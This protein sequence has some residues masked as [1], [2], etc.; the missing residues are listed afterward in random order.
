MLAKAREG[1]PA[2]AE[3]SK[4]EVQAYYDAHT[5]KF[6]EPERRRIAAIVMADA[7]AAAKV[8]VPA[9]QANGA[10]WGEL[11]HEHS[12][13]APDKRDPDAPAEL[14]GDLGIVGPPEDPKGAS[15][16]VPAPVQKAAFELKRIGD[17]HPQLIEHGG[18]HYIVRLIG[19]SKGHTRS[20]AEADRAIRVAIL[21][22]KILER[23]RQLEAEL[24]KRF[25]VQLDDAALKS[26]ELP[27]KLKAY[28]P[29]WDQPG[30]PSEG[31]LP[32]GAEDGEAAGE[33]AD[34]GQNGSAAP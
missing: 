8:L 6:R 19:Q 29:L 10:A 12:L 3:I 1:L 16:S 13:T 34:E 21:Q 28:K 22:D 27:E 24:R 32:P 30:D 33:G 25:P 18:R 7:T 31:S 4:A 9:A 5:D 17:V 14:E 2:P 26:I 15:V 20:L 11:F 23:E